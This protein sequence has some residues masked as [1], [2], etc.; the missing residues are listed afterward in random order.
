MAYYQRNAMQFNATQRNAIIDMH[1]LARINLRMQQF[2]LLLLDRRSGNIP[3]DI[4]DFQ[5]HRAQFRR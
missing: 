3:F 1:S 2:R 5:R 4:L